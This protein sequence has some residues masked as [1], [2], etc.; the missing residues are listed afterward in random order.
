MRILRE[1]MSCA[2]ST[3][4]HEAVGLSLATSANRIMEF[5][6]SARI[7]F[8][9]LHFILR[10]PRRPEPICKPLRRAIGYR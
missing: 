10:V 3:L 9:A 4:S 6:S 1:W 8:A 2:R 7:D 5:A